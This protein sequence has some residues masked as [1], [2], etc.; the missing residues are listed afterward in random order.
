[1]AAMSAAIGRFQNPLLGLLL[2]VSVGYLALGGGLR[3]SFTRNRVHLT[4]LRLHFENNPGKQAELK[5]Y[6]IALASEQRASDDWQTAYSR[7]QRVLAPVSSCPALQETGQSTFN[8]NDDQR[9]QLARWIESNSVIPKCLESKDLDAASAY[10][11]WVGSLIPLLSRSYVRLPDRMASAS[12]SRSFERFDAG[13]L[14]A[15]QADWLSAKGFFASATEKGASPRYE[16]IGDI[17]EKVG[18]KHRKAQQHFLK[19]DLVAYPDN[20]SVKVYLTQAYNGNFQSRE[21][22]DT[23]TPLL[24]AMPDDVSV[25]QQY[26]QA[27][28][29][30]NR[31][32]EA[33][34]VLQ[35][36]VRLAPDNL[37][38]LNRLGVLYQVTDQPERAASL[39][40]Q[41][42]AA[43]GGAD[44][45]WVWDHLG[46]VLLDQGKRPQAR[47]AYQNA[48]ARAPVELQEPARKKLEAI[49]DE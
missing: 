44:A 26:A 20:A 19:Q 1:M 34:A 49:N 8:F 27:L 48:V 35:K 10:Y 25:L 21:A 18:A 6:A 11:Y 46:D 13:Q 43:S 14:E 41:A 28:I 31:V 47:E 5:S 3:D 24:E 23:I 45:Y 4:M 40:R 42:L 39:F 29:G 16:A 38:V 7:I 22:L 12:I 15:A 32:Q 33:E 2:L 37:Q 36:S 9:Q 17:A 30:L